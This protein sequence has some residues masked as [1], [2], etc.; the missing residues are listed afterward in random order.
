MLT[1][2]GTITKIEDE[3]SFEMKGKLVLQRIFAISTK[4]EYPK[5]IAFMLYDKNVQ[6]IQ[7]FQEGDEVSVKFNL[8][9]KNSNGRWYTNA[10]AFGIEKIFR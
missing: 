2:E 6:L 4:D 9:S 1:I 7:D 8:E 5:T 10:K 3:T